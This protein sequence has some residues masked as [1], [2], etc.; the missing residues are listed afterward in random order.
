MRAVSVGFCKDNKLIFSALQTFIVNSQGEI[1]K[2]RKKKLRRRK[3]TLRI[4]RKGKSRICGSRWR[5]GT[6]ERTSLGDLRNRNGLGSQKCR[7]N[8]QKLHHLIS[9]YYF[10][11]SFLQINLNFPSSGEKL[12]RIFGF[13][14]ARHLL[15][16]SSEYQLLG[17]RF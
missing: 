15:L 6:S 1:N 8:L 11:R 3:I 17:S 7:E 2:K 9:F 14:T 4:Q 12:V 5:L 16:K 13:H 10:P